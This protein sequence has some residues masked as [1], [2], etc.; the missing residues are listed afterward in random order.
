MLD[1][2]PIEVGYLWSALGV[3]LLLMSIG[4]V[5]LTEWDLSKRLHVIAT[6]SAISGVALFVL[7]MS[8]DRLSAAVCMV[9]VGG[10]MG[11]FTPIAWGII[12]EVSPDRLVGRILTIY[13][14]GAM[15]SAIAGMTIFGWITQHFGERA[16]VI[17]IGLMLCVTAAVATGFSRWMRRLHSG[18]DRLELG[19]SIFS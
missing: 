6:S 7:S 13:G 11:V 2:G 15:T 14:T 3:G 1:L 8:A 5:R 10:G 18:R 19:H 4:L 16:S 9:I 17:G 12:Q